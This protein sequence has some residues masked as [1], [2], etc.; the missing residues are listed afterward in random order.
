MAY[1]MS[2]LTRI[3]FQLSD[4]EYE[5]LYHSLV[6]SEALKSADLLKILREEQLE[7]PAILVRLD[8]SSNAYYALRSRLNNRIESFYLEQLE[9][10]KN[11]LYRQVVN[12]NELVLTKSRTIAIA[13]LK[14]LEK[15]LANNDLFHE[16]TLVYQALKKL[17]V[18]TPEHFQYSQLYNK[19]SAQLLAF[20]KTETLT[21]EYFKSYNQGLLEMNISEHQEV[22]LIR[23]SI[24]SINN[25]YNSHRILTLKSLSFLF[26]QIITPTKDKKGKAIMNRFDELEK[27][28]KLYNNDLLY[29]H[30]QWVVTYLKLLHAFSLKKENDVDAIIKE[31]DPISSRLLT[32][33][34]SFCSPA[35]YLLIK[36]EHSIKNNK[37]YR[38]EK[39]NESIYR[40]YDEDSAYL[41][42]CTVYYFYRSYCCFYSG[43]NEDAIQWVEKAISLLNI[44]EH[45]RLLVDLKLTSAGFSF[46]N[47]DFETVLNQVNYVQRILRISEKSNFEYA[48]SFMKMIKSAFSNIEFDKKYRKFE[49][50]KKQF[51]ESEKPFQS[52]LRFFDISKIECPNNVQQ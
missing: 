32:N 7:E 49:S 30:L 46:V 29:N 27:I 25:R 33:Y 9:G 52:P 43:N 20:E 8:V 48:Y 17:H 12:I 24:D 19:H 13:T 45:E 40:N 6:D 3:I 39:L 38:L 34:S 26:S 23:D 42:S 4:Q 2:K 18:N 10:G 1:T 31:L 35:Y 41:L 36:L 51:I 28:F 16:L 22:K 15:E 50:A 14:K 5:K 11:E 44:K 37:V 21:A 47:N